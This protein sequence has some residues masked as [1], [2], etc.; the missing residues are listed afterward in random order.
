VPGRTVYLGDN[1]NDFTW[2]IPN[3]RGHEFEELIELYL[4]RHVATRMGGF[5][6]SGRG[7]PVTQ[8]NSSKESSLARSG[9]GSLAKR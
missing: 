3:G 7:R 4:R 9:A 8:A 2:A 6:R 1:P 5:A